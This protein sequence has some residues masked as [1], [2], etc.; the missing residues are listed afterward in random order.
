SMLVYRFVQLEH[1][2]GATAEIDRRIGT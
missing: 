1:T 2:N